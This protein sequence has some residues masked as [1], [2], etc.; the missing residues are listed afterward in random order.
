MIDMISREIFPR[1]D[2]TRCFQRVGKLAPLESLEASGAE[3]AGC[4]KAE[5]AWIASNAAAA[6]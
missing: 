4:V 6:S 1:Q 3:A 5:S 2:M